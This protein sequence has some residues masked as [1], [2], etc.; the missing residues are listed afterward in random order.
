MSIA[1]YDAAL[2][3][4]SRTFGA[5][6]MPVDGRDRNDVVVRFDDG[7]HQ[8]LDVRRWSAHP[9]RAD[10]ALLSRA[11]GPV[12]D[13]GCGPGRMVAAL[14][15]RGIAAL[16]LDL[17]ATAVRLARRRGAF[18][19][20]GDVFGGLPMPGAWRQMLLVDGNI[21]I[22]GQP[23]ALLRTLLSGLDPRGE[24]LVELSAPET[25]TGTVRAR[26][27]PPQGEPGAWFP[28]ARVAFGDIEAVAVESGLRAV[29]VWEVDERWFA[30]L[31]G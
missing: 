14:A 25:S 4:A 19:I 21:G 22:G 11:I 17:S 16:G 9:D 8:V 26:L 2:A 30:R 1:L 13:V 15:S 5:G 31:R 3:A 20:C 23:A 24:I 18:A 7:T 12:L 10:E 29:E 28:W 6:E 27:E